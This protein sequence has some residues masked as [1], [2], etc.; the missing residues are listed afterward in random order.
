MWEWHSSALWTWTGFLGTL[1]F[2]LR[3]SSC[4]F[5]SVWYKSDLWWQLRYTQQIKKEIGHF[6]TCCFF[7]K[8]ANAITFIVVYIFNTG[9]FEI[10]SFNFESQFLNVS[11]SFF[12]LV[13]L[14]M[15]LL[16]VFFNLLTA[17]AEFWLYDYYTDIIPLYFVNQQFPS[18]PYKEMLQWSFLIFVQWNIKGNRS[19]DIECGLFGCFFG[20]YLDNQG[21]KAQCPGN[22][23]CVHH[24]RGGEEEQAVYKML[25][26]L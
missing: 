24:G 14:K 10:V 9:R 16:G 20:S 25:L 15:L 12:F 7:F 2:R 17:S 1:H 11:L 8:N 6:S 3:S 26:I 4:F 5:Y 18:F 21:K 19:D 22:I 23:Y 13:F